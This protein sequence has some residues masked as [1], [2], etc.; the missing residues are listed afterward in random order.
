MANLAAVDS[1][2]VAYGI[3]QILEKEEDVEPLNFPDGNV[4]ICNGSI[5]LQVHEGVLRLHSNGV[6]RRYIQ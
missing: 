3:T 6:H 4:V 5:R 2:E 1:M